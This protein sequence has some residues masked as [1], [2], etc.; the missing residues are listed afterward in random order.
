[1]GITY[2]ELKELLLIGHEIE[3][4]YNKK[5]YSINCGQDYWYLTEYYNKNQEFKTTEELLEKGRIEGK[6][7]EDIWSNVDTRA[8]Y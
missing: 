2:E 6:S 5:R 7:L 8:V 1:M 3:F 4:E